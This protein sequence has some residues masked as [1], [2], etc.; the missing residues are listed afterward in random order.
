M[1]HNPPLHIYPIE[2]ESPKDRKRTGQEAK[3]SCPVRLILL[4][5]VFTEN[6]PS[7]LHPSHVSICPPGSENQYKF[8]PISLRNI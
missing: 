3:I 8:F 7:G 2:Q 5:S 1:G 6:S 4:R